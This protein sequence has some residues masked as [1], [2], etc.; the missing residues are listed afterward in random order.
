M[1]RL[2]FDAAFAGPSQWASMYRAL[3]LQVVPSYPPQPRPAQWKRP[4]IPEWK[5]FQ[6]ELVPFKLFDR[7]YGEGEQFSRRQNMG[8]I[9]GRASGNIFV[10]DLDLYKGST[11][12]TWWETQIFLNNH[13]EIP[14]CWRSRTGGGGRHLFF[15][16]PETWVVPNNNT[17]LGI[18]I[19]GQGGFVVLPPSL[20]TDGVYAWESGYSPFEVGE[21]EEAPRWLLDA[22]DELAEMHGGHIPETRAQDGE[23]VLATPSP[24]SDINAWGRQIDGR[25]SAMTKAVYAGV[26]KLR[27]EHAQPTVDEILYQR[28]LAFNRYLQDTAT[29]LPGLDNAAGLEREGRGET[30][31]NAKWARLIA[32]WGTPELEAAAARPNPKAEA[33]SSPE[34]SSPAPT[35]I[36]PTLYAFPHPST[37]PP[38]EFLY[39]KRVVRRFLGATV[40]PGGLGK[41]SLIIVEALALATGLPLLGIQPHGPCR[42][43]LWNGEDP[44]DELD[45][46]IAA[47]MQAHALTPELVGDRLYVDSG[48]DQEIVIAHRVAGQIQVAEPVVN[49]L[50]GAVQRL[51][52]DVL[53]IDPFVSSHRV[54]EN[55]NDEM[56]RVVKQWNFIADK[57]NCAVELV[58][59]TRKTGG[60]EVGVEDARGASALIAA[61]RTARVLNGMTRDE[62]RAVNL[63]DER[64]RYFRVDTGKSNLAPRSDLADWYKIDSVD[65]GNATGLRSSDHVGVVHAFVMPDVFAAATPDQSL[66]AL[67]AIEAGIDSGPHLGEPWRWGRGCPTGPLHAINPVMRVM[68]LGT[69]EEAKRMIRQWLTM[70]Q[71]REETFYSKLDRK[72]RNVLV[73][74]H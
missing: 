3:G 32:K 10:L 24:A 68:K 64:T 21:L 70:K 62:A 33:S 71:L 67:E 15:R 25:E 47:A 2:S 73:R 26:M 39:G 13:G 72:D 61:A 43:W 12:A 31:F 35:L 42:V 50:I 60:M 55:S 20:H 16:A 51:K 65:I 44:A 74:R 53:K 6:E 9:T 30:L 63:E 18:D 69:A 41:S 59:H 57:G 48:R 46:R 56:D 40:S 7:W 5:Q 14:H 34:P 54:S 52:L 28:Q 36:N 37:I 27:R 58:H 66:A 19:K 38:R 4:A 45:R 17:A 49:G 29:R 8:M 22:I 1:P 23:P 11:A